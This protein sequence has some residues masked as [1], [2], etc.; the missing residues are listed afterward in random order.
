MAKR[1]ELLDVD[2]GGKINTPY[3]ERLNRTIRN[4][5]SAERHERDIQM[6]SRDVDF[7]PMLGTTSSKQII[8]NINQKKRRWMKRKLKGLADHI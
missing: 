2:S 1:F 7:F 5:L 3:A 4:S 6:N 8:M